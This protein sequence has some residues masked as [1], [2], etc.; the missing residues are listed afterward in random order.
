MKKTMLM[1]AFLSV[2]ATAGLAQSDQSKNLRGLKGVRLVVMFGRATAMEESQRPALLQLLETDAKAKFE[3]AGIPL[4]RFSDE[5]RDAGNP[6]LIVRVTLDEPNGFVFPLVTEVSLFQ[7]VRLARDPSIEA[8]VLTWRRSGV[9]AP[10]FTV[11]MI[12]SQVA[13]EIDQFLDDYRAA[14]PK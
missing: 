2:T 1:L 4:L 5:V 6:L 14:N 7:S 8:D 11:P 12:R 13:T 10:E 3:K 9:G